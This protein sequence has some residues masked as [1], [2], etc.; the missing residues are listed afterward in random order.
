MTNLSAK[1]KLGTIL[2]KNVNKLSKQDKLPF[3]IV[4]KLKNGYFLID[5]VESSMN[6]KA[7][8]GD[9]IIDTSNHINQSFEA[10]T[11]EQ[12]DQLL[13]KY[14]FD[15]ETDYQLVIYF[16]DGILEYFL[17][18]NENGDLSN[19]Q[20]FYQLS[21]DQLDSLIYVFDQESLID[22]DFTA[23]SKELVI[24]MNE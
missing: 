9:F 17:S 16:E 8:T 2:Q 21:N 14:P 11:E 20:R 7:S 23:F 22:E 18:E 10:L 1:Q 13:K 24:E 19:H 4:C 6:G 12:R 3:K 15:I 5:I